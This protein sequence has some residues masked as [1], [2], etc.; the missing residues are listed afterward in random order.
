MFPISAGELVDNF[1]KFYIYEN[2][3]NLL[4]Y[5]AYPEIITDSVNGV[6]VNTSEE[7]VQVIHN[8]KHTSYYAFNFEKIKQ[9]SLNK[10]NPIK[11]YKQLTRLF[12]SAIINH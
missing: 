8:F 2:L 6:L 4:V 7:L 5:G 11:Y 12:K 10:Y 3:E 9:N 1:G